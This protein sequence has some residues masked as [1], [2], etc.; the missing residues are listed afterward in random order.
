LAGILIHS[1]ADFNL[2]IPANAMLLAWIAGIAV[3][4]PFRRDKAAPRP[5]KLY[6]L[7]GFL[8]VAGCLASLYGAGWL[9][10]DHWF[11]N[12]LGAER[13]FCDF[14]ICDS[15]QAPRVLGTQYG[16]SIS[17]A[18]P[19]KILEYLRRDPAGPYRWEDLGE[20]LQQA[21]RTKEAR[22]SFQ[23]AV[24]L[25]PTY[26]TMLYRAADFYFSLG[27]KQEG[28]RLAVAALKSDPEDTDS[29]FREYDSGRIPLADVLDSGLP[30]I[31]KVW[32]DFLRREIQQQRVGDAQTVWSWMVPR[33]GYVDRALTS[34]YV[35]FLV[36]Q[37]QFEAA[38]QAWNPGPERVYN[39]DFETNPLPHAAFDWQVSDTP[40][41]EVSVAE[42]SAHSGARSL[43]LRF[44]G[45]QNL[46]NLGVAQTVYLKPGSYRFRAWVKTKD[47][48]TDQGISFKVVDGAR[49]AYLTTQPLLGSTSSKEGDWKSVE[50][51][52]HVGDSQ[53][54]QRITL[55]RI[56]SLKFDSKVG[57]TLWIDQ[58]SIRPAGK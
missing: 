11:T 5:L 29:A 51:S 31:P 22:Y 57:G 49:R 52:L 44:D 30:P 50:G 24:A 47:L 12:D 8:L 28:I 41:V 15:Y 14:G 58:I 4:L 42:D 54:L 7:R 46:T 27:E 55:T 35:D 43:K 45:T 48:G 21:G 37:K 40:G 1:F 10:Y 33:A 16:G 9:V 32:R 26:P 39:G 6:G 3:A 56:A 25:A 38:A 34:E 23:R 20:S 53:G 19:E 36:G 2:H 18:P 13:R 17:A